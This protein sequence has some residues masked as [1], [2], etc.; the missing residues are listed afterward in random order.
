MAKL[1]IPPT[2]TNLCSLQPTAVDEYMHRY[3]D[4]D[5]TQP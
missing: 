1:V 4:F 3:W 2:L 5:G